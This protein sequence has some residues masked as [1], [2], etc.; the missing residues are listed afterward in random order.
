MTN[1]FEDGVES[2]GFGNWTDARIWDSGIDNNTYGNTQRIAVGGGR[3][4]GLW[5]SIY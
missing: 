4:D 3:I 1:I 2:G 5:R